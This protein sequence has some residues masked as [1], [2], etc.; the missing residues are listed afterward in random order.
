MAAML[1]TYD[2]SDEERENDLLDYLKGIGAEM[3]TESSYFVVT[4][5]TA[6]KIVTEIRSKTKDKIRVYVLGVTSWS[7][8]GP[9]ATNDLL[10]KA[11]G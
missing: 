1:I 4:E 3:I 5:T 11:L 7:G 6:D 10:K 8:Y 9:Q 2:L